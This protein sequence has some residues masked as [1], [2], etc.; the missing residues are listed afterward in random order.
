[1]VRGLMGLAKG[2]RMLQ[3]ACANALVP[4][5]PLRLGSI[6]SQ[7]KL[8]FPTTKKQGHS[9]D[10]VSLLCGFEGDF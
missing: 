1:M 9:H 2:V 7:P 3:L 4:S 10:R 5:Q 6:V 8:R